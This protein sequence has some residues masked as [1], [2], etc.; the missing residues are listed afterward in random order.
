MTIQT[1]GAIN[2]GSLVVDHHGEGKRR[3]A[4]HGALRN[5]HATSRAFADPQ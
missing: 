3:R 4:L 2:R 1:R 5:V